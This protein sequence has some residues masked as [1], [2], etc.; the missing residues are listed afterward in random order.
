MYFVTYASI[1]GTD[2]R[3]PMQAFFSR[4]A[5]RFGAPPVQ[6]NAVTGYS[7]VEAWV[8]AVERAHSLQTDK[9]RA[10]LDAFAA[11]PLLVGPTT[12]SPQSHINTL[13]DM[14]VME[15]TAGKQGKVVGVFAP[16]ALPRQLDVDSR[17]ASREIQRR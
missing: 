9:V 17:T 6:S 10:A 16:Q 13:R 1:F 4:F 5:A 11:E 7:V 15:I 2:P 3:A 14:I 12:F 8:R